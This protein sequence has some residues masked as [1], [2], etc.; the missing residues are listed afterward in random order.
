MMKRMSFDEYFIRMAKLASERTTCLRRKVG[1]VIVKDKSVVSTGYN[2]PPRGAPSCEEKGGCMRQKLNIPS[3]QRHELC[4]AAHAEANAIV[5]AAKLGNSTE[6]AVVYCTNFPCSLCV[7][8]MINAG[9]KEIVYVDGYPDEL[10]KELL[11]ECSMNIRK[12]DVEW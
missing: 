2:G 5:Q 12:I 3:G 10:S 11:E 6:N 4:R 7:K 9:I 1:A 8:L